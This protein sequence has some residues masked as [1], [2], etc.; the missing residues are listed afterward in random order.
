MRLIKEKNRSAVWTTGLVERQSMLQ[1][2][3]LQIGSKSHKQTRVGRN[4]QI[5][6]AA[7]QY[8][9]WISFSLKMGTNIISF[10]LAR[11][12]L[13]TYMHADRNDAA[14]AGSSLLTPLRSTCSLY[15]RL[16]NGYDSLPKL[17]H[18]LESSH[19]NTI[20]LPFTLC[21]VSMG[22]SA[23]CITP[24]SNPGIYMPT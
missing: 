20:P 24:W 11:I 22:E 14:N 4:I 15:C 18:C 3:Q 5:Q 9:A 17:N 8:K 16:W 13:A 6:E 12:V 19:F 7:L 10:I 2:L 23:M 21:C 1:L